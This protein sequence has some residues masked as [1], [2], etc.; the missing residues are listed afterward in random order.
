MIKCIRQAIIFGVSYTQSLHIQKYFT[1]SEGLNLSLNF[2][3]MDTTG[4]IEA[5]SCN[6]VSSRGFG[7]SVKR[8]AVTEVDSLEEEENG[9]FKW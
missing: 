5:I 9:R 7:R 8:Q 2:T 1:Y 6:L 3:D 4:S